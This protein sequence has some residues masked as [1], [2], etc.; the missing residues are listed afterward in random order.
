MSD[1]GGGESGLGRWEEGGMAVC[2]LVVLEVGEEE[3]CCCCCGMARLALG[4]LRSAMPAML[5]RVGGSSME[6]SRLRSGSPWLSTMALTWPGTR[7][8]AKVLS[9]VTQPSRISQ[10]RMFMKASLW[11]LL[12]INVTYALG[13]LNR[14]KIFGKGGSAGKSFANLPVAETTLL[15]SALGETM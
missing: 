4:S 7:T 12:G 13:V 3:S 1:G 11:S 9:C 10:A 2:V 14:F 8:H 5:P 15:M 6:D